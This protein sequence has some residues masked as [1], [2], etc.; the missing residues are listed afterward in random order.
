LVGL[1]LHKICETELPIF[2]TPEYIKLRSK[3]GINQ[4]PFDDV[5]HCGDEV[6][7]SMKAGDALS[8][9]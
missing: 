9:R 7:M 8:C 4:F 5:Q 3:L 1:L 6:V 2:Q